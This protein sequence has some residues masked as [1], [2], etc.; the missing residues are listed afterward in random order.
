MTVKVENGEKSRRDI[1]GVSITTLSYSYSRTTYVCVVQ[2]A[3]MSALGS[4]I[5]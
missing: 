5:E 4:K 1:P 2:A 3:A